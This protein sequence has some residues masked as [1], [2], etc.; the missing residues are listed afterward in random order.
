MAVDICATF[1]L[2][3]HKI[4]VLEVKNAKYFTDKIIILAKYKIIWF[5][6]IE[7]EHAKINFRG[8]YGDTYT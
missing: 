1:Q 5:F 8:I 3:V 2:F 4:G 7:I 6:T